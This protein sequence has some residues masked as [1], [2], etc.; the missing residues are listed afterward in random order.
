M[1]ELLQISYRCFAV[2]GGGIA[3]FFSIEA[4][5]PSAPVSYRLYGNGAPSVPMGLNYIR[6]GSKANGRSRINR[7][8]FA[9]GCSGSST[10]LNS[11]GRI[12]EG[13]A[14]RHEVRRC[15]HRP[16]IRRVASSSRVPFRRKRGQ[17]FDLGLRNRLRKSRI[18][19][20]ADRR[21]A[22]RDRYAPNAPEPRWRPIL[23][24][25]PPAHLVYASVRPQ[26]CRRCHPGP[27]P[28]LARYSLHNDGINRQSRTES[29]AIPAPPVVCRRRCRAA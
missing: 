14:N 12:A 25:K 22:N 29:G 28:C 10:K 24:N 19:R 7:N 2:E 9:S 20:A 18:G 16:P 8:R 17:L 3:Q 13:T 6:R 23:R 1:T 5:R 27:G 15:R 4:E 21:A 26:I 11:S